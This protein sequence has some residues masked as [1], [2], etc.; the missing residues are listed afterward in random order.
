MG[1]R[2]FA[3]A[4]ALLVGAA[5]AL[6]ADAAPGDAA[7]RA[8]VAQATRACVAARAMALVRGIDDDALQGKMLG[9]VLDT[10]GALG[11]AETAALA[12]EA[13]AI[14]AASANDEGTRDAMWLSIATA[15]AKARDFTAATAVL[16][17]FERTG[18]QGEGVVRIAVELGQAR[19]VD[20]AVQMLRTH[21]ATKD[22]WRAWSRAAWSLRSVAVARGETGALLALLREAQVHYRAYRA[23]RGGFGDSIDLVFHPSLFVDPLLI[24]LAEQTAQGKAQDALAIARAAGD[25][26]SRSALAGGVAAVLAHAGRTDEALEI[27]LAAPADEQGRVVGP[28]MMPTL[29]DPMPDRSDGLLVGPFPKIARPASSVFAASMRLAGRFLEGEDRDM[30]YGAVA[31]ANARED[32]VANAVKAAKPIKGIY[33]LRLTLTEVADAQARTGDRAASI[34]TFARV[35]ELLAIEPSDLGWEWRESDLSEL[36]QRQARAGQPDEALAIVRSMKGNEMTSIAILADGRQVSFDL[37]RRDALYEIARAMAK[38]GRIEDAFAIARESEHPDVGSVGHGLGVVAEGLAEAGRMDDAFR[39]L[40]AVVKDVQRDDALLHI[41][42]RR[43]AAGLTGETDALLA[44][45]TGDGKRALAMGEI[46]AALL[47]AGDAARA[48][49]LV[50]RALT[51][52]DAPATPDEAIDV[53]CQAMRGLAA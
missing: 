31:L 33:P 11:L 14:A 29:L 46:A 52:A 20:E 43:L 49:A 32:A 10:A 35:R 24:V 3:L 4:V 25:A 50:Q 2:V 30:A 44:A 19:H 13:E 12:R 26:L 16:A 7:W 36:A 28:A 23:Q 21:A 6:A 34:A 18:R 47:Q 51:A 48:V 1:M 41:V 15:Y 5:P 53:L 38:A 27:A 17:R 40:K 37:N 22:D 9:R 39:A 45:F 42:R 8:C